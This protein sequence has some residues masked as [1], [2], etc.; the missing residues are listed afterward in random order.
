[1]LCELW[2]RR[3][4]RVRPTAPPKGRGGWRVCVTALPQRTV[5]LQALLLPAVFLCG[6]RG[7]MG[8][9]V[10]GVRAGVRRV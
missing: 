1:M 9:V 2:G 5:C 10:W 3:G 7:V 4:R 6:A 8:G